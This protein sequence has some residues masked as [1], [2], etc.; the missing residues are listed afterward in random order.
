MGDGRLSGDVKSG[1]SGLDAFFTTA[2]DESL[3]IGRVI[4]LKIILPTEE[5]VVALPVQS[6]YEGSRI[7]K[8]EGDRLQ[9]ITIQQ[10]G[11]YVDENGQYQILVRSSDIKFGDKLITTQLPR[12]ITGLLVDAIDASKFNEARAADIDMSG[13]SQAN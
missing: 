10:V 13:S 2:S 9:G 8:V 1:Q 5:N 11:D 7:Y 4:N 3:D 12:A 6:I